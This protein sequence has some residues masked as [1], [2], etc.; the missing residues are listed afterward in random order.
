MLATYTLHV[1]SHFTAARALR[2]YVGDCA[3]LHN[4]TFK[5]G[6][7]VAAPELDE[8]GLVVDFYDIKAM[9]EQ[10]LSLFECGNLNEIAPFNK[11]NPSNENLAKYI[12]V[13]LNKNLVHPTI[14]LVAATVWENE[15]AGATYR[16]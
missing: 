8:T 12:F 2:N 6:V 3:K 9:L 5:V 13:E 4:Q 16:A 10:V 14:K 1:T 15:L 7:D 11:L